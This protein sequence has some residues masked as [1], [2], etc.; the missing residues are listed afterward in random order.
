MLNDIDSNNQKY[1]DSISLSFE[2]GVSF[3]TWIDFVS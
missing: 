2:I 1:F 3:N